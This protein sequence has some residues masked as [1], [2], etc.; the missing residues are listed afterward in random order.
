MRI[1][2]I[3]YARGIAIILMIMG[4]IGFG[5]VFDKYIHAFHMPIFFF[6]SGW[7]Y[8]KIKLGDLIKKQLN[9]LM[10]PY[11]LVAIINLII[12][13]T[14]NGISNG[15][16]ML[17]SIFT[18]NT[19]SMPISGALWFITA[20]FFTTI[21]YNIIDKIISN[22]VLKNIAIITLSILGCTLNKYFNIELPLA[23]SQGLVGLGFYHIGKIKN[24][25]KENEWINKILNM[26]N[27]MIIICFIINFIFIFLNKYI[28]MRTS[29]YDNIV[30]FWVNSIIS[31]IILL[32]IS[33]KASLINNKINDIIC[34]IGKNSLIYL[35]FNQIIILI[36]MKLYQRIGINN[37]GIKLIVNI[38][39]LIISISLLYLITKVIKKTKLNK[40]FNCK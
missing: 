28:N 2:Y 21:I 39:I 6:V 37:V 4:D 32:N 35:C 11:F 33:K 29:M 18:Y 20:I 36:C 30:L 27:L 19:I 31:I 8:K 17:K 26:N 15:I 16:Y 7:F 24:E 13:T 25:K 22:K 5:N 23:L 38:I 34:N 1:K 40:F 14:F 12:Y 9:N 10:I 3:D